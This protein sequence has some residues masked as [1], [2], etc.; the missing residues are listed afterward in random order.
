MSN[1]SIILLSHL[2]YIC[3]SSLALQRS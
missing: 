3:H 2:Y 1:L